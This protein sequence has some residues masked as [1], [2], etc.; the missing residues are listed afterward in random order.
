MNPV[1]RVVICAV[2]GQLL[3]AA[4]APGPWPA[5]VEQY[6]ETF[7]QAHPSEA[8]WYGMHR[9]DDRLEDRSRPAIAAH[10]AREKALLARLE[11]YPESA[12]AAEERTERRLLTSG[13][14]AELLE[15]EEVRSWQ[16]NP[17]NY[18][19]SLT[20]SAWRLMARRFAPPETRLRA[21]ILRE[22]RMPALLRAA[23][24]NL[25]NPPRIYTEIAL[26]QLPG[27][28]TFFREDVPAGFR[29]VQD[30]ELQA[31]FAAAN[32]AVVTALQGYQRFLRKDLLPAS[33][34]SFALGA[35]RYRRKL[36]FEEMVDLPL[37]RLLAVAMADLR[38]NRQAL[39]EV[40]AR[41]DPRA[42]VADII[43]RAKRDHPSAEQMLPAFARQLAGAK[44]FIESH[45]LLTL[46]DEPEPKLQETP[47][48]G[49]ALTSAS[50]DTPGPFE[51]SKEAYFYVTLPEPGWAP[52][53]TEDFL[54]GLN[55]GLIF[56]TT[57]H[58]A[59]PGHFVQMSL[60]N[61]FASK[62]RRL[63]LCG[64]ACEGWAHYVEQMMVEEGFAGD[65]P[66]LRIGQL[67]DALL[68][69]ARFVVGISLHTRGMT[70]A[71][72]RDFFLKEGLQAQGTADME[73]KRGT[74]DP[75]Y[76]VY[77]LGKLEILKLREDWR[78][79][80]GPAYSLQAF[81]DA[82]LRLGGLP[83]QLVREAMLK[84]PGPVL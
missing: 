35:D 46:P 47:P 34:G 27:L 71:Q 62:V 70:L 26:Q 52:A 41:I 82:F 77:T 84:E 38:R 78:R 4:P 12:L 18:S 76:L 75:T 29:E 25:R 74:T 44:A 68:R 67:Q 31:R 64:T 13:A 8:T 50:M 65:D 33:H 51:A 69:D 19:S 55:R 53:K 45:H 39:A 42:T 23:R 2:A 5:L 28:I 81:H 72:A 7:F 15:F 1:L 10:V 3:A 56:S 63:Y 9:Y 57:V 32:A 30:G 21:L 58:E 80:Q 36:L 73:T 83:I 40:A 37:D 49:R 61:R 22:Q 16:K 60:Q 54:Q 20:E 6:Y 24:V 79:E 66:W 11:A 59:F 14:R 48:F 17:D 43:D